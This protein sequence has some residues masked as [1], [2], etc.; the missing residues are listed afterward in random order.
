[1]TTAVAR[2][3]AAGAVLLQKK[4]LYDSVLT[5]V[6]MASAMAVRIV[7]RFKYLHKPVVIVILPL[8]QFYPLL[9]LLLLRLY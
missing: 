4:N 9:L 7:H 8:S 6:C 3:A 1:M 2:V 5:S